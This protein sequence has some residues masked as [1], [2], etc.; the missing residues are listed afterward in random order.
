MLDGHHARDKVGQRLAER[1][2]LAQLQPE[3]TRAALQA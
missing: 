3:R 2:R 1:G